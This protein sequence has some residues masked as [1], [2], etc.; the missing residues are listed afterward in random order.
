MQ[1][2][3][4]EHSREDDEMA[5]L[6][7]KGVENIAMDQKISGRW[8]AMRGMMG[9]QCQVRRQE[10]VRHRDTKESTET[11]GSPSAKLRLH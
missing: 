8:K 3:F 9:R 4:R 6:G 1:H 2:I 11:D 7:A 10:R 5:N